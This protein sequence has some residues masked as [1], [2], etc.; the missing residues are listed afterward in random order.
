MNPK[1]RVKLR[2]QQANLEMGVDLVNKMLDLVNPPVDPN[3]PQGPRRLASENVGPE[4][5]LRR[6]VD[7]VQAAL[8]GKKVLGFQ[9]IDP[10]DD[11]RATEL[12]DLVDRFT[13]EN[14]KEL[15]GPGGLTASDLARLEKA[16]KTGFRGSAASAR[17]AF[18]GILDTF[19][20]R[21]AVIDEELN[22]GTVT[23]IEGDL[24]GLTTQ[25]LDNMSL[26]DLRAL[27]QQAQ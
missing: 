8:G 22:L 10:D 23:T 4:G 26:E 13:Q 27:R 3:N 6:G 25:D 16:T 18:L 19:E 2:T 12:Q 9:P 17:D 21:R 14:W 5:Q 15:V 11:R 24:G 7:W 1:T 20:R